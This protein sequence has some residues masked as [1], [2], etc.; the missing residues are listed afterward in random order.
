M[1]FFDHDTELENEF[2][3][4]LGLLH[5]KE[6][7]EA[8][9]KG[10]ILFVSLDSPLASL[11]FGC[12]EKGLKILKEDWRMKRSWRPCFAMVARNL[13]LKKVPKTPKEMR[14]KKK[15]RKWKETKKATR[16]CKSATT[17]S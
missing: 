15:R 9:F 11:I 2:Q 10:E 1:P 3:K 13:T 5:E 6:E 8:R 4:D 17:K 12:C 16:I 14:T 7:G